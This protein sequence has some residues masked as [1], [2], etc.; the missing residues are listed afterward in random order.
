MECKVNAESGSDADSAPD[1][2]AP[3]AAEPERWLQEHGDFLFRQACIRVRDRHTAE[4]LVQE[5]FLAGIRAKSNFAGRSSERTWLA[6]ILKNKIVDHYRKQGRETSFTNLDFLADEESRLFQK[7][8]MQKGAWVHE[9]GPKHWQSPGQSLEQ[10]EFWKV[11]KACLSKLPG[12]V[13]QAFL[14]RELD[15]KQTNEICELLEIS[16][17]NLWVMLHRARMGLRRCLELNW[18]DS[19]RRLN[20]PAKK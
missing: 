5:T 7:S 16:A 2:K 9:L 6:G 18:F 4:D 12:N 11:L 13:S 1:P 8:G 19:D 3:Q 20:A 17:N 15:G 14:L 10:S